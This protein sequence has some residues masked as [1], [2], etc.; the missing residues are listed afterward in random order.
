MAPFLAKVSSGYEG[1]YGEVAQ[2]F[3]QA[4]RDARV[5]EAALQ[6]IVVM[7]SRRWVESALVQQAVL[8]EAI[9][10]GLRRS[11]PR[12]PSRYA[13]IDDDSREAIRKGWLHLRDEW[14][15]YCGHTATHL[16]FR[17]LEIA[18]ETHVDCSTSDA[19]RILR[20]Y[21]AIRGREFVL[22]GEVSRAGAAMLLDPM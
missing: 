20:F 8:Y 9:D 18:R 1:D 3:D 13:N 5:H 2:S 15:T 21:L 22:A 7:G 17:A 11:S 6:A 14:S 16:A 12:M 19:Q 10:D 4:F